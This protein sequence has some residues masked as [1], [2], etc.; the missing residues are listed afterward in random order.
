MLKITLLDIEISHFTF[1]CPHYHH[2]RQDH[3]FS[4][5]TFITLLD[6]MLECLPACLFSHHSF[7]RSLS[8]S[9]SFILWKDSILPE[10]GVV[11]VHIIM[12]GKHCP[13]PRLMFAFPSFTSSLLP[14]ISSFYPSSLHIYFA[15]IGSEQQQR[16]Q[17]Q[18]QRKHFSRSHFIFTL[19]MG[20]IPAIEQHHV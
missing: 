11:C 2:P 1:G 20:N 3:P 19:M 18:Q 7:A 14:A 6:C 12:R 5:S 17:Q 13:P 10:S 9:P 4:P 16:K 8:L 15:C